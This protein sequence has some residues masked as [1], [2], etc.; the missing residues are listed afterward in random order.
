MQIKI[1]DPDNFYL[2]RTATVKED[3]GAVLLVELPTGAGGTVSFAIKARDA[4]PVS[5]A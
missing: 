3:R 2:G 5:A 1:A 4:V